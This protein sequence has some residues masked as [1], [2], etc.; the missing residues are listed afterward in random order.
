MAG[1]LA[2]EGQTRLQTAEVTADG[3][4]L[5]SRAAAALLAE[6]ADRVGLTSALSEALGSTRERRSAHDPGRVI[7]DVAVMLADG[8]DCVTDLDALRGQGRLLGEVASET[9]AHRV[10]KSI[11]EELLDGL[12]EARAAVRAR[13]WDAGARP[14]SVTLDIDATIVSAQAEQE[15]AAGTYKRSFGFHPLLCHLDETGEP[16]AGLLRPGNAGSNTADDHFPVLCLALSQLP[17]ADLDRELLVRCDVGGAT[18]AFTRHCRDA[19]IRFSVGTSSTNA[20]A[21]RS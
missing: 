9:T 10:L 15:L 21:R 11:D 20:C 13:A 1:Q 18:H 2:G 5:I 19:G 12:R 6:L 4:G 14:A 8:G 16:L 17:A 7:R 3:E